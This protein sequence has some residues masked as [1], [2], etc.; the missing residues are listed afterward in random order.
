MATPSVSLAIARVPRVA[1]RFAHLATNVVTNRR[2]RAVP[3][4]QKV[5]IVEAAGRENVGKAALAHWIT[6]T[7]GAY[8]QTSGRT[9]ARAFLGQRERA[10]GT[11]AL[12]VVVGSVGFACI[13]HSR[14]ALGRMIDLATSDRGGD[15][16]FQKQ[17]SH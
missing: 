11:V 13:L 10:L 4:V 14:N 9:A 2:A 5:L 17:G 15:Q 8:L 7:R 1:G 12:R 6:D 3:E 16:H